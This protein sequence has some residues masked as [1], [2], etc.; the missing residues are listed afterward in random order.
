MVLLGLSVFPA[1]TV[2]DRPIEADIVEATAEPRGEGVV[3]V[4]IAYES[5]TVG[6]TELAEV[7]IRNERLAEETV[8]I[9]VAFDGSVTTETPLSRLGW[10]HF[11]LGGGIGLLLGLVTIFT[12][13]G[14]GYV[15]GDGA[16]GST[17]RVP[18]GEEEGFYWRT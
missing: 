5:R 3:A 18:V 10:I 9:W 2:F 17:P 7:E 8:S 11:A 14:Y 13:R 4:T 1:L 12:L 15:R 16:P 6:G